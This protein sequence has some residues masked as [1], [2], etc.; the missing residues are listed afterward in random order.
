MVG[1][2]FSIFRAGISRGYGHRPPMHERPTSGTASVSK[3]DAAGAMAGS[4]QNPP[5]H[6]AH[7]PQ[8]AACAVAESKKIEHKTTAKIKLGRRMGGPFEKIRHCFHVKKSRRE[9]AYLAAEARRL[10]YRFRHSR[11]HSINCIIRAMIVIGSMPVSSPSFCATALIR[12][13][14]PTAPDSSSLVTRSNTRS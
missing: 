1:L 2:G 4:G 3:I 10:Y 9:I 8:V 7:L 6:V 14:P 5:G 12:G 13:S 11:I